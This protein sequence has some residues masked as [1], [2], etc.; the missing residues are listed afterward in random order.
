MNEVD[1]K[2]KIEGLKKAIA[3]HN[4]FAGNYAS[5]LEKVEKQLKDY[6]KIALPPMVFDDIYEAI[7][8]A[9]EQFDFSDTDNFDIE[10]GIE[11]DGRVYCETHEMNNTTNLV[12]AIIEK[13]SK[14]F[15][16]ADAPEDEP[17]NEQI[18]QSVQTQPVEEEIT[19]DGGE[20]EVTVTPTEE[21]M[22]NFNK[23]IEETKE[24]KFKKRTW[25]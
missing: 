12:E 23:K 4:D 24:K 14:I 6:N 7:E 22:E 11:Y 25:F 9:V 5:E 3:E 18:E 2:T 13:V 19:I 1:L 20:T 17:T 21:E 10:Y 15:T 16:E 8:K